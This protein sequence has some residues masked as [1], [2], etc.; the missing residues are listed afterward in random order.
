[1]KNL[2]AVLI[3]FNEEDSIAEALDSLTFC[4][5]IVVVDSFSTDRTRHLCEEKGARFLQR[6]WEGYVTQ[7]NYG[8]GQS[9][10]PWVLCLD[11]DERVGAELRREL[12]AWRASADEAFD[13]YY[14]PRL[15]YFMGRWIRHTTWYPD[16]QLRLFRKAAGRWQGGHLHESVAVQ[17]PVGRFEHPL[18][19][20]S[21]PTVGAYLERLQAY[22]TLA[23]LDYQARGRKAGPVAFV[24][25]PLTAFLKNY[26]LRRGFL[27]GLPGLVVSALAGMSVFFKYLRLW[28]LEREKV[29][30][31]Q[32]PAAR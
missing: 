5:E 13:G 21:Y 27:D 9:Q 23:A 12:E 17:G 16:Y 32:P 29:A 24:F 7:K 6:K 19:H 15:S 20:F 2:S 14:L 25:G 8:V 30:S 4:D 3:T 10:H 1:M 28:E 11:A 18:L 26:I 31:R 22:S